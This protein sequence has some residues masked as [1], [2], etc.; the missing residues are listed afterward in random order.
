M[1]VSGQHPVHVTMRIREELPSLRG[2]EVFLALRE[3]LGKGKERFGCRL[4]HFSVQS[5]HLHLIL[6]ADDRVAL[7]RGVQG[8]AI[9]IAKALNRVWER[10]GKVFAERY[11]EQVLE[12]PQ[13]LRN[14]LLY[15]LNNSRHH[16]VQ[17]T[18]H[19]PDA[20]SS[21]EWFDGWRDYRS[22]RRG[23]GAPVVPP[24]TFLQRKLWRRH[25]LL[26]TRETP[27]AL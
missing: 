21:G 2:K 10:K 27:G 14:A 8:L 9:R 6:E 1:V 16:D 24:R 20:Y 7:T 26:G 17:H 22:P 13:Q 4:N 23:A 25:G 15:V 18:E 3:A 19:L 11:H 5:N 12:S